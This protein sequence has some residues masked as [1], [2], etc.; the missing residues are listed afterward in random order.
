MEESPLTNLYLEVTIMEEMNIG[1]VKS[2]ASKESLKKALYAGAIAAGVYAG[3]RF[4]FHWGSTKTL[5][6]M[7]EWKPETAKEFYDFIVNSAKEMKK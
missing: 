2:F 3:Y 5:M 7:L 1:N 4:G 6:I